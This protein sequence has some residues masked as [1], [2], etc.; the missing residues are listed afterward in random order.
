MPITDFDIAAL[1]NAIYAMVPAAWDHFDPGDDDG[2]CWA[3]KHLE[4]IDAI[5]HRG[6]VSLQDWILDSDAAAI[7]TPIGM[8]HA[9]FYAPLPKLWEEA[10]PLL[11]QARIVVGGHALGAGRASQFC[12]LMTVDKKPPAAR[13]VFGEPKPGFISLAK[14]IEGVPG[15][16]Y[17]NGDATHHDLVTDLPFSFPPFEY[18]HP[19]PIIPIMATPA[20]EGFAA[21]GVFA[22]HHMPL[23]AEAAPTTVI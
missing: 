16:S 8:V 6:S 18:V 1:C 15:R 23:Y 5:I 13:V 4:G 20:P 14:I 11:T 17:R 9:G 19:T 3:I 12:G 21:D 2:A 10:K 22:W 7:P